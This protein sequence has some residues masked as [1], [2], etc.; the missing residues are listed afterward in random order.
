[1]SEPVQPARAAGDL[2]PSLVARLRAGDGS[3][4]ALL[5]QLYREPIIRFCA[6]YLRRVEDA[7]DAAQEVFCKVLAAPTVPD[8]FRAWIYRVARNHCL[9]LLRARTRQGAPVALPA[10]S[11][12]GAALTGH[13]TRVIRQELRARLAHLVAAMPAAHREVLCL[14]YVEG[15]SRSEIGFVLDLPESVVKSRLFEGLEKLREHIPL[16]E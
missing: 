2:T 12:L 7:E 13:L 3:V 8:N 1:M 4:G 9:N 16:L 6:G 10:D 5:D 15:L 11:E 14:R